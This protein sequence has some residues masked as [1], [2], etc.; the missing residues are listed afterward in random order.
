ME[1]ELLLSTPRISCIKSTRTIACKRARQGIQPAVCFV[2]GHEIH[3]TPPVLVAAHTAAPCYQRL[4]A[5][6]VHS[7]TAQP[8]RNIVRN[9][10][11]CFYGAETFDID[12]CVRVLAKCGSGCR[13]LVGLLQSS[14]SSGARGLVV[15]GQFEPPFLCPDQTPTLYPR[16]PVQQQCQAV[17]IHSDRLSLRRRSAAPTFVCERTYPACQMSLG[18]RQGRNILDPRRHTYTCVQ[19]ACIQRR[20]TIHIKTLSEMSVN[21]YCQIRGI[22]SCGL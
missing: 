6:A 22:H 21:V 13:S 15:V 17:S 7:R 2:F 1:K 19:C 8:I 11:W 9:D 5:E 4:L 12:K 14:S 18:G 16:K 3:V 10:A 20:G